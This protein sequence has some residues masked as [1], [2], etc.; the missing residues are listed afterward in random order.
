MQKKVQII[1]SIDFGT[2]G[3][4]FNAVLDGHDSFWYGDLLF[5]NG[6][7]NLNITFQNGA[8]YIPF[9]TLSE[10]TY[11]A[12]KYVSALS[13]NEGGIVDLYDVNAKATWQKL[14]LDTTYP[15]IMNTDLDYLMVGDLKGNNGNF[16]MDMNDQDKSKTD[17]LYILNAKEGSGQNNIEA[18]S[19]NQFANVSATNTLRFASV[20]APAANVRVF[21]DAINIYGENLWDYQLLIG[22][23]PYDVSDPE[24]A[25]YNGSRDGLTAAQIDALM[26]GGMNWYIYGYNR[27]PSNNT[28]TIMD[29]LAVGYD[30]ATEMDRYNKRHGEA[31]KLDEDSN[32]WVRMKRGDIGRDGGYD[33]KYTMGQIGYEMGNSKDNQYGIAIDYARG[34]AN[35]ENSLGTVE[36][37]RKG[38]MLYNTRTKDNGSYLDLVARF[39]R[40]DT[41]VKGHNNRTGTEITGDYSNN[42]YSLSAEYGKKMQKEGK[43]L[44]F[45]PQIQLQYARVGGADYRTSNGVDASIDGSNSLIGRLGFRVGKDI[46]KDSTIYF[47]A[48]VLREFTGG[49]DLRLASNGYGLSTSLAKRGTW[50]DVGI[51]A[52]VRLSRATYFTCDIEKS[53][54][55]E[56]SKSWEVNAG[57]KWAF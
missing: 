21:K 23:S 45:E 2:N 10:N 20:A 37:T 15:E 52:D 39:G 14:G 33:G 18:Y 27:T 26:V 16:R 13:L 29:S 5:D 41:D 42:V 51:G 32:V 22:T 40:V 50:Y 55:G 19:E 35:L 44:F 9:G 47:K 57:V 46:S 56:V 54:G 36:N 17:M 31:Q 53:F 43:G 7:G 34:K 48:D 38:I 11:G 4:D 12:K 3:G 8:E 49:Q 25:V 28:V 30:L 24:N 1:G 6:T